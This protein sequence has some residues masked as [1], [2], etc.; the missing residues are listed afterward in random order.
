MKTMILAATALVTLSSCV[1]TSPQYGSP[2]PG[3][4]PWGISADQFRDENRSLEIQRWQY[5]QTRKL[6]GLDG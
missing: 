6:N 4:T 5:E 3:Y 2:G 1:T